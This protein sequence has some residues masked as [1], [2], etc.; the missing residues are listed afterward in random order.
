MPSSD[1][2][3]DLQLAVMRALWR[4][5]PASVGE[6]QAQLAARQLAYTTVATM[7]TRLV[8]AGLVSRERRGRGHVYQATVDE[9]QVQRSMTRRLID[10][11]FGGSSTALANH[12]VRDHASDEELAAIDALLEAQA[13]D[14]EDGR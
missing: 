6:V 2:L 1:T 5:G 4:V 10:A 3:T 8:D 14:R 9:R 11:V 12:L 13:D 7:L